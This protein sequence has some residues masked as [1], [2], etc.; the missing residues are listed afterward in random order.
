MKKYKNFEADRV[1]R[2]SDLE[3][4]ESL[5]FFEWNRDIDEKHVKDIM[6]AIKAG[7][8]MP[9]IF[10]DIRTGKI[11]DGQ[12][13]VEA[14]RRL[15]LEGFFCIVKILFEDEGAE[16]EIMAYA[17]D[18]NANVKGWNDKNYLAYFKYKKIEDYQ[19]LEDFAKSNSL[20]FSIRKTGKQ[21]GEKNLKLTTAARLVLGPNFDRRAIKDGKFHANEKQF[22]NAVKYHN[23]IKKILEIKGYVTDEKTCPNMGNSFES[24]ITGWINFMNDYA[25]D[26]CELGGFDMYCVAVKDLDMTV[27]T[28]TQTWYDRFVDIFQKCQI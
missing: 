2:I 27:C 13:R 17:H 21:K 26:I 12:H 15:I 24:M 25:L 23:Q 4:L 10:I 8:K 9:P 3:T 14:Y 18:I 11:I 6:D 7:K 19:R 5:G 1:Y 16:E 28:K 20:C 22:E